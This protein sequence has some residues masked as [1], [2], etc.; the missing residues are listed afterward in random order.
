MNAKTNEKETQKSQSE[1]ATSMLGSSE[2]LPA[3]AE[4]FE[5]DGPTGY[6]DVDHECVTIPFLK[7]AQASTAEAKER[8]SAYIPGL[9]PGMFF[10]PA[11][12][13]VYGE[14]VKLVML[15]FYRQY[16]IYKS[17]ETKSKFMGLM[18]PEQ[19]KEIIEPKAK[20]E[21]S[22]YLDSEGHRYVDTRNFIVM[23]AGA[24]NDGLMLLSLSSTGIKPSK[25]WMTQ[26][27]N[28]RADD[29]R[30]VPIWANVWSLETGYFDDPKGSYYQLSRVSRLGYIP[31]DKKAVII[32]AFLD[33][34][35]MKAE[36]LAQS[37]AKGSGTVDAEDQE[38]NPFDGQ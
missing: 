9:K 14:N 26:A 34:N 10:C 37:H 32:P 22:Y 27:T 38:T 36:D 6:E 12:R 21:R 25:G 1:M 35:S 29:G 13:K 2:N 24:L 19:F 30:V 17:A 15:R 20:R 18:L 4:S 23:V 28:I 3:T 33:V 31:V 5:F 16:S 11:T 7:I 8:D